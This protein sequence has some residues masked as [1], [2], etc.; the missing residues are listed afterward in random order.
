MDKSFVALTEIKDKI[1]NDVIVAVH[2]DKRM[3]RSVINKISSVYSK[4]DD[5]GNN[6]IVSYV[7]DQIKKGNLLDASTE[8]APNWFTV[9]GLQLPHAVQTILDANNSIHDTEPIVNSSVKKMPNIYPKLRPPTS[10][11]TLRMKMQAWR[12][13]KKLTRRGIKDDIAHG[14]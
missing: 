8:K 13:R 12:L 11:T 4:T 2:I 5:Y 1:G 14:L 6:K 3:G 9:S 7:T 10:A